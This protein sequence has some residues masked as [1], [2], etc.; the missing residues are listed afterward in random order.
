VRAVI[1]FVVFLPVIGYLFVARLDRARG[2]ERPNART[3]ETEKGRAPRFRHM[4]DSGTSA[5]KVASYGWNLLDVSSKA[6]ADRLPA[7]TR[8]LVWVGDYDNKACV[9]EVPDSKLRNDAPAIAHD[10]KVAG[11]VISDEADPY[12]CPQAPAEHRSRTRLLHTLSPRKFTVMVMDSNSGRASVTQMPLWVGSADYIALDPYPC[13]Q[14]KRR[15]DFAWIQTIIKAADRA[16]LHYWGVA[17]AFDDSDWRWPTVGEERHMLAQWGASHESGYMTFSWRWAGHAL[18]ER[19][20]LLEVFRQFNRS[21]L[22]RLPSLRL[23]RTSGTQGGAREVSEL[24]YT[25]Q[26]STSVT[27]DWR[28]KATTLRYGRA[29][30]KGSSA[31]ARPPQVAPFSSKGPFYQV[32]LSG[33]KPGTSYRYSV[34]PITS[35]FTTPPTAR[36]RFDLEADVGAS[37][38]FEEV[39]TTQQQIAADK[40]SFVIVAGDLTYANDNGQAAVDRHFNDVMAWSRRAA[41]MP[42]WGNHEWDESTDDLRN[43]KGRFRIPHAQRAPDAPRQGCCGADWGWFDAGNT[44]FISYPEPYSGSAWRSW[45]G[46]A[47]RLMAAA[48]RNRRIRFIVTFGHR[49]AYSTGYHPGDKLLA[50]IMDGLGDRFSKY[51]LN[52]N[53]HSHDYERFQPIHH[54]VH[55]T[56]GGGGADLEPWS[57]GKDSRTAFRALHLEHLRVDVNARRMRIEAVCGPQTSDQDFDC[58]LGQVI[59]TYT[60]VASTAA[61]RGR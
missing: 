2:V 34:G 19:P 22:R 33:L 51:V 28:G 60:I 55:I 31:K 8:G 36:F 4:I 49:P 47:A 44:R 21:A 26:G 54:V 30:R 52:L 58:R 11:F 25:Y 18:A 29:G 24:H 43:Y 6:A 46:N 40:P 9:W 27:F 59:D 61:R 5:A 10:P 37:S 50:S 57:K 32:T 12:A 7:G 23:A 14:G 17:Q 20:G 38:D 35:T 48:Q 16:R 13:R 45:S 42:A 53:G 1:L 39:R 56:A 41:Y 3:T 15:C